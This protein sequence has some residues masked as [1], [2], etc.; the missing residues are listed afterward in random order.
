MGRTAIG[1]G[2]GEGEIGEHGGIHGQTR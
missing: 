2:L 1:D